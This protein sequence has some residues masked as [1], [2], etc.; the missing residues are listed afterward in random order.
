M[1]SS[2]ALLVRGC[3]RSLVPKRL[4]RART[5][6][7]VRVRTVWLATNSQLLAVLDTTN[8][9]LATSRNR[10]IVEARSTAALQPAVKKHAAAPPRF[11]E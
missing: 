9:L 1:H 7:C 2:N 8:L 10:S 4:V 6:E 11:Q 5:S 3:S